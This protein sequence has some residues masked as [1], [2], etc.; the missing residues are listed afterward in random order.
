MY[1]I[2]AGALALVLGATAFGPWCLTSAGAAMIAIAR[3][4]RPWPRR[5]ALLFPLITAG[6]VVTGPAPVTALLP[7][8]VAQALLLAAEPRRWVRV[9]SQWF[10]LAACGLSV[11]ACYAVLFGGPAP[12]PLAVGVTVFLLALAT[13]A[14]SPDTTVARMF[15]DSSISAVLTRR[16]VGSAL[17]ALPLIGLLLIAGQDAGWYG[18][19]TRFALMVAANVTLV[20]VIGLFTGARMEVADAA[21]RELL[22]R[23]EMGNVL[24][25]T[26]IAFSAKGLD[27]VYLL[28]SAAFEK[29]YDLPE[30]GALGLADH[31][32]HTPEQLAEI[33]RRDRAVLDGGQPMTFEDEHHSR[34]F[35]T[36]VFS[37]R[38]AA[39][40][41]AAICA[42]TLEITDLRVAE[43]KFKGLL[44]ASPEA[45]L[46]VNAE[47]RI[48]LA[49]ARA[50]EAFRY[51]RDELI[52]SFVER[53][54]PA[55][56]RSR[57]IAHRRDYLSHPAPRAMGKDLR[58]TA[59]RRDGTE[60]PVEVSLATVEGESGP[61]VF[62]A[63]QD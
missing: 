52:G 10:A 8:A 46:C 63:V 33:I 4:T 60:F 48:V 27:G 57:H 5:I 55:I 36:S 3:L 62:A 59:V 47:G 61:V 7:L 15:L 49:N 54:V 35:V 14:A 34:T 40:N 37:M 26:P 18:M 21:R 56:H 29:L 16:L 44:D 39:G 31:D 2:A 41:P 1:Q 25:Q 43:S 12:R 28:T 24:A 50:V 11:V 20:T 22:Q 6:A 9:V 51:E 17:I 45:M 23:E 42:A 30:G 38:D 58:L 53:L 19:H 13:L 32:L